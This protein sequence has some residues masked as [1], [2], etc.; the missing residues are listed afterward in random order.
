MRLLQFQSTLRRNTAFQ[1]ALFNLLD[2]ISRSGVDAS[3]V[4]V[5]NETARTKIEAGGQPAGAFSIRRIIFYKK[6]KP[7]FEKM[8][9]QC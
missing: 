3:E 7:V 4:I 2:V 6:G 9:L 8:L 5:R 1:A